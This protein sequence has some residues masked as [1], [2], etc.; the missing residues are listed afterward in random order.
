MT[1]SE[2]TNPP[3]LTMPWAV[4][5]V[6]LGLNVRAKSNPTIDP[7]PP[8]EMTT[9]RTISSHSGARP[10]RASTTVHTRA[11]LAMIASTTR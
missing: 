2:A 1:N 8:I 3:M 9:T 6:A 7:G 11:L 10:G 4:P 5:S